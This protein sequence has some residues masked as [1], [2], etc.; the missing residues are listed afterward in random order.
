MVGTPTAGSASWDTP[1]PLAELSSAD[2]GR[3]GVVFRCGQML[4]RTSGTDLGRG[5]MGTVSLL[6]RRRADGGPVSEAVGKVFHPEYLLQLRTDELT[7]HDHAQVLRNLDG[8][9]ALEHPS[10]LPLMV[11]APIADNHLT[12]TPRMPE[13]LRAAIARGA[14]GRRR[15]VELLL[16][17][18][19]GLR[20]LHGAGYLHRDI[21]LR[22]MLVDRD[23]S[24]ALLFDFDLCLALSDVR[25]MS[26]KERYKGRVFGSP[27][28]SV[29]P[30][31]LD[32]ALMESEIGPALDIYGVGSALFG[33]FSDQL[34]YGEAGDMWGLLLRISDG[35]VRSGVSYIDY[36]ESVPRAVRPIIEGCLERDPAR[37][38][39]SVDEVIAA[40]EAV[41]DDIDDT[42]V[43]VPFARTLRYGDAAA[44]LQAVRDARR[45]H[46]VTEVMIA[47]AD[48]VL[49]RHGYQIFRALG[50]VKDCPIFL[51]APS[52]ELVAQGEFPD[53]NLY[54]KI[55]TVVNLASEPEDERDELVELWLSRYVPILK[56]ARQGLLTPLHRASYDA[57][58][59]L[60]LLF[61]EYVDDARFGPDLEAH[62]LSLEEALGLGY[63]VGR[64]VVRLHERGLAHNN[65]GARSLLLKGLR[66]RRVVH[67]AMVGLVAPSLSDDDMAADVRHL[68]ALALS[69][70]REDR[71]AGAPAHARERLEHTRRRLD[72]MA[73]DEAR[74]VPTVLEFL[75]VIA[76][77][78]SAIDFN[79]GVLREN[80]GDLD[81]YALLLVSHALYGRLWS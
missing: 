75:A 32:T 17:V 24:R 76:D 23:L 11:S 3:P 41:L 65:I 47:T 71:V 28:Y 42:R 58:A 2:L 36:P 53:L 49:A 61:S 78:L 52:P 34:P 45:D 12:V 7:R 18:L 79:F 80:G 21:T 4:Y 55:V 15:R 27:G 68:A 50:R 66:D 48:Q 39:G 30:E 37:R 44:R 35:V 54:P 70:V 43:P 67:P 26:Y 6:E 5:G 22:N 69:W 64:Q 60:L 40:L 31:I 25:N 62:D 72:A 57:D 13:T 59:E 14:L 63:L 29:A 73:T 16:Q 10:L 1:R 9:A 77:G 74:L 19:R 81:A 46:T 51:A 33:L 8:I 20:A 56:R 38:T